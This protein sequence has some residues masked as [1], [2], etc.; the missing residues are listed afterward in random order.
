MIMMCPCGL[1]LPYQSCC[2]PLHQFKKVA[3][4]AQMLMRSRF[5][6][7][8]L[9]KIDYIIKTTVPS[10]QCQL[11]KNALQAWANDTQ[12]TRLQIIS[13]VP[14]LT[15][16]HAQVHFLAYFDD[17]HQGELCH[18][19]LSTFVKIKDVWYFLDPTVACLL[20]NKQPCL[21]GSGD[22]FKACCQKFLTV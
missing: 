1:Q 20:T 6:A 4:D 16:R 7:F 12:W 21:C 13:H 14:K 5:C 19:E 22:K 8:Y 15:K 10:Q 3:Q 17:P 18:D 11:D 2:E 9:K